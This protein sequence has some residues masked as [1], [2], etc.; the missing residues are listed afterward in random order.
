[1]ENQINI[2]DQ[3]TQQI[4][5]NSN[6]QPTQISKRSKVNPWM[7]STAALG[8]LL[9]LLT[10]FYVRNL[11]IQVKEEI[12]ANQAKLQSPTPTVDNQN[13]MP[14][15]NTLYLGQYEGKE[16]IFYTNDLAD[17]GGTGAGGV[18]IEG[19]PYTGAMAAVGNKSLGYSNPYDFRQ[20]VNPKKIA[21]NFPSLIGLV[22]DAKYGTK[23]DILYVSLILD[24]RQESS[25]QYSSSKNLVYKIILGSMDKQLVWSTELK[26]GI[27][28]DN[29]TD[30]AGAADINQVVEDKYLMLSIGLCF[31][32]SPY[33]EKRGM[34][35]LNI[36]SRKE[37][38]LGMVGDI[39][40]NTTNNTVTYKKLEAITEQCPTDTAYCNDSIGNGQ[41][42]VY[43]PTGQLV[44]EALP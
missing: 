37:K 43:K 6:N 32:C 44:S 36:N 19:G 4:G 27:Y 25:Q 23:N 14:Q 38:F 18:K 29:D 17:E 20:I 15:K 33:S 2:G 1:M 5:Q 26:E 12:P 13:T 16:V 41:R 40:V 21:I 24:S 9:I 8:F 22:V 7:I 31:D 3:N 11:K 42:H 35:V 39:I 34:L 10:F 28:N 30:F